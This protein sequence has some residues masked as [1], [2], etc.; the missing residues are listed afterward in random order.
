MRKSSLPQ[1]IKNTINEYPRTF[2]VLVVI[3]IGE[4]IFEPV[5]Q[6]SVASFAPEQMRGR[7]MAIEGHSIS[8]AYAVGP[9]LAGRVFDSGSPNWLWYSAGMIGTVLS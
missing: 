9:L 1:R 6:A 2:W 8:I 4:L 3:T 7:Y 5:R